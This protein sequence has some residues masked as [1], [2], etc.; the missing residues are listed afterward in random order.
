MACIF[1]EIVARSTPAHIVWED[2]STMAFLDINPSADGHMLVVP[3]PHASDIWEIDAESMA[4]V[5]RTVH[6]MADLLKE[7]LSP[8]GM[9]L[10]QANRSAGWQD[11]FH[12]HVHLVPRSS[13][14]KLV[15]PWHSVPDRR[16]RLDD[17]HALLR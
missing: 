2:E 14:D 13:D 1:C 3:K 5:A 15:R 4:D 8:E 17:V 16:N 11:V 7:R 6:R 12:L 10:L 9:T